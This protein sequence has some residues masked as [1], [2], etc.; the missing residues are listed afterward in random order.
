[1]LARPLLKDTIS[2]DDSFVE[3]ASE[4]EDDLSELLKVSGEPSIHNPK[5][6]RPLSEQQ[7]DTFEL[8]AQPLVPPSP[9]KERYRSRM[10]RHV[11]DGDLP[12]DL[13]TV[14]FP[15]AAPQPPLRSL[16]PTGTLWSPY[17]PGKIFAM[18]LPPDR[19]PITSQ[20][21]PNTF[22]DPRMTR[23]FTRGLHSGNPE[24]LYSGCMNGYVHERICT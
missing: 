6:Q 15:D 4:P 19:D 21:P 18:P 14:S 22:T 20:L 12:I 8:A 11:S 10:K 17:S 1:V 24:L 2:E 13:P 16:P 3:P 9:N 5:C 23:P 7:L